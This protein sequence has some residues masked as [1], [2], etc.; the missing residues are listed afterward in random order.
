MILI[1][2]G[3]RPGRCALHVAGH[4]QFAQHGCDIVCAGVSAL[5][6]CLATALAAFEQPGLHAQ[7]R[8][9]DARITCTANGVADVLFYAV[10]IGLAQLAD[11][12]PDSIQMRTE[13]YFQAKQEEDAD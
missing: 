11:K 2:A 5:V 6:Q 1:F 3:R 13:G 12:Y 4:A 9:G 10:V 8:P 7:L